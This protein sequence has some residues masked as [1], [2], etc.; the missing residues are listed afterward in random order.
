MI[1]KKANL[2]KLTLRKI[3]IFGV[4]I[5]R[6]VFYTRVILRMQIMTSIFDKYPACIKR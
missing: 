1:I 6:F 5:L 4:L 2:I 3:R